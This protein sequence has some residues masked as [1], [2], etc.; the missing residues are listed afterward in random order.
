MNLRVDLA[1]PLEAG[2]LRGPRSGD[3]GRA[4]I[5]WSW[6][7]LWPGGP[8]MVGILAERGSAVLRQ[9]GAWQGPRDGEPGRAEQWLCGPMGRVLGGS[10][11]LLV[12]RGVENSSTI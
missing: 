4:W 6:V 9:A 11:A 12:D 2:V 10:A 5:W 7:E 3:P 1:V 8:R